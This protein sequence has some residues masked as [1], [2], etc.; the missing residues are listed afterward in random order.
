MSGIKNGLNEFVAEQRAYKEAYENDSY[1]AL[2]RI[3]N[4]PAHDFNREMLEIMFPNDDIESEDFEDGL[5]FE[6]MN[7]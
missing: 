3:R 7:D 2:D 4:N 1:I 6:D 5:D